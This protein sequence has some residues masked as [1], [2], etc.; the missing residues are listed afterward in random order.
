MSKGVIFPFSEAGKF[1][2]QF[3]LAAPPGLCT[4]GLCEAYDDVNGLSKKLV[5]MENLAQLGAGSLIKYELP[6]LAR[7]ANISTDVGKFVLDAFTVDLMGAIQFLEKQ[8]Q[9]NVDN[10]ICSI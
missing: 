9:G 1:L 2:K 7:N 5:F 10:V 6:K 4:N 3:K 8:V